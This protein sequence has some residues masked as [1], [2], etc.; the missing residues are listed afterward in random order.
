MAAL[1]VFIVFVFVKQINKFRAMQDA[2]KPK[3]EEAP[4]EKECPYCFT[5]ISV[6]AKRCP[7]CTSELSE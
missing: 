2:K 7:C 3:E 1:L 5:K 6:K 4:T